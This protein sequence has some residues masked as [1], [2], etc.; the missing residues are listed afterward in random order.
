MDGNTLQQLDDIGGRRDDNCRLRDTDSATEGVDYTEVAD[1]TI[2]IP[3]GQTSAS[4]D[5]SVSGKRDFVADNN[6]RFS[7]SAASRPATR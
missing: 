1:Y 6:E 2:T 3:A 4:K 5:F 7:I